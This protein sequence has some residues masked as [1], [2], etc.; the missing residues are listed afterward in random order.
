MG[1]VTRATMKKFARTLE[2]FYVKHG[3]QTD[4]ITLERIKKKFTLVRFNKIH[5]YDA[6]TL[7]EYIRK[8]GDF[9]D[10]MSRVEYN[11]CELM[12]L[13]KCVG[14]VHNH[15]IYN[16][17]DLMQKRKLYYENIGLTFVFESEIYDLIEN[18]LNTTD[19]FFDS[20]FDFEFLPQI[21]QCIDNFVNIDFMRCQTCIQACIQ[22]LQSQTNNEY[23][24][25]RLSQTLRVLYDS[26]K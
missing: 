1:I 5:N 26:L 22:R 18:L 8:T 24:L 2:R 25:Y 7:H 6:Y 19:T 10:P 12:R 21:L 16:K 3:N 17:K 9:R 14:N 13:D 11:E 23:Y 4:P 15:L 20:K